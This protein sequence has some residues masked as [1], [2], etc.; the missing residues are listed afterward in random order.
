MK[1]KKHDKVKIICGSYKGRIGKIIKVFPKNKSV[2][3][4]NIGFYKKHVKPRLYRKYP[5]GGVIEI[6]KIINI[7]N[8][9]FFSEKLN[10]PVRIG[11]SI[12]DQ[13]NKCRISRGLKNHK[14]I[15]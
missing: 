15:D 6:P 13:N 8:V 11:Y 7:S 4:E 5:K 9:M 1:I 10:R 14:F 12:N 3:I 2:L